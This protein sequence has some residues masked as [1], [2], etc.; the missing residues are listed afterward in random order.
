MNAYFP[1]ILAGVLLNSAAQILIKKGMIL[2]GHFDFSIVNILPVSLK[3]STSPC[4][5]AGMISYAASIIIWFM[6]LSR[7]DVSFAYPMLSIGYIVAAL[8]GKA[9]FNE[10]LTMTRVS[11]I[12]VICLGV[13]LVSRSA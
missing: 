2:I 13:Y 1:L 12:V 8:A 5:M 6:V 7:V 9:F 11:G 10:P 3:L 4:I